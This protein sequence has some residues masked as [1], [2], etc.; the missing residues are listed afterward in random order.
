[1]EHGDCLF[2]VL[3]QKIVNLAF[4][5]LEKI[6]SDDSRAICISAYSPVAY[7]VFFSRNTPIAL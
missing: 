2:A 7:P 1:V 6:F 3:G 4:V 5:V